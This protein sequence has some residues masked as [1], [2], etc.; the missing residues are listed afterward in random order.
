MGIAEER[1]SS[2]QSSRLERLRRTAQERSGSGR[3]VALVVAA[4]YVTIAILDGGSDEGVRAFLALGLWLLIILGIVLGLWPRA[5]VPRAALL[6]GSL[7]GALA[8]LSAVSLAWSNDDSRAFVETI[9]VLAHLGLF[10]LVVLAA[11]PGSARR[12]LGGLAIGLGAVAG[13]AILARSQPGLIGVADAVRE[14][15]GGVADRR[16]SFPM[17][18]WNGLGMAMALGILLFAWLGAEGRTRRVRAL[19]VAAIPAAGLTLFMTSSRGGIVAL[20]VGLAALLILARERGAIAGSLGLGALGSFAL[21]ALALTAARS[22]GIGE[23]EAPGADSQGDLLL[24]GALLI[25]GLVALVRDL[26]ERLPRRALKGLAIA[27]VAAC[28]LL[29]LAASPASLGKAVAERAGEV[30]EEPESLEPGEQQLVVEHL[31]SKR[32]SGRCQYWGVAL[33]AFAGAPLV[34]VGAGGYESVWAENHTLP[35][36][37]IFAHSVFFGQLAELGATGLLLLVGFLLTVVV[38][39]IRGRSRDRSSERAVALALVAAGTFAAAIDWMWELPGVFGIV[40]VASAL[41]AG[42][43][44]GRPPTDG[45]SR[46]GFGVATLLAG[47]VAIV[48]AALSFF[49]QNRI[50]A[51]SEAVAAGDFDAAVARADTAITVLPWSAEAYHFKA[52]AFEGAGKLDAALGAIDEAIERDR[53]DWTLWLT[54][55][56]LHQQR[57]DQDAT[58]ATLLRAAELAPEAPDVDPGELDQ[59][60]DLL[61]P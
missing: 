58:A 39:G 27:G 50:D 59:V 51:S 48:A 2:L 10:T 34:G 37:T 55:A 30:C 60:D 25:C 20:V 54:E 49:G 44:L 29:V 32:G 9:R 6:A 31:Q 5:P 7:L 18:Y 47:W 36:P 16:L 35:Q 3:I 53:A 1:Q 33:D 14:D 11:A 8:V 42:P 61:V 43:A 38:T 41:L 17:E 12:W 26:A 23:L 57:G 46:F 24:A 22:V 56:R 15:L 52:V 4:V 40:I 21:I 19:A 45:R 28:A 13:I